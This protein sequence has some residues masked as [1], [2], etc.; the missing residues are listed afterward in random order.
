MWAARRGH[1]EI[2]DK[3]ITAGAKLNLQ[4]KVQEDCECVRP[5]HNML[6]ADRNF[7]I[8]LYAQNV[9]AAGHSCS[10]TLYVFILTIIDT[11]AQECTCV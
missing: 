9:H 2:A 5:I 3:L 1:T 11:Y 10:H 7:L 4:D 6:Q 8:T